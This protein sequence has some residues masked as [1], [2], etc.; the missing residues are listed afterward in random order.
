VSTSAGRERSFVQGRAWVVVKRT[1]RWR[2]LWVEER[3]R[4]QRRKASAG[5]LI[6]IAVGGRGSSVTK[7]SLLVTTDTLI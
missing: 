6:F 5:I 3:K 2:P 4:R 1:A 7:W